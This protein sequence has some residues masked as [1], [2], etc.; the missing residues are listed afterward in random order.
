MARLDR[1]PGLLV[2]GDR[3][4]I[5]A[6]HNWFWKKQLDITFQLT[7]PRL[8]HYPSFQ[9]LL[10]ACCPDGR[11]L[12]FLASEQAFRKVQ[13]MQ[14][15]SRVLPLVGDLGGEYAV[16]D[17]GD[18]LRRRGLQLG[19]LYVSNVEQYLF[20]DGIFDRWMDNL[21][22][23]PLHPEAVVI[24]AYPE[25]DDGQPAAEL[26][27]SLLGQLRRSATIA[28]EAF[29]H[30]DRRKVHRM[31]AVV[32]RLSRFLERERTVGYR[33]FRALV[34]DAELLVR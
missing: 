28:A 15:E 7:G 33:S 27:N 14:L 20:E 3:H 21:R 9:T 25:T 10:A 18:E 23:L 6:I 13:Q 30:P 26:P 2:S 29:L 11:Q 34:V 12:G 31:P 17:A 19:A 5:A 16:R 4:R 32:H 24:R 22:S 1:L 8:R